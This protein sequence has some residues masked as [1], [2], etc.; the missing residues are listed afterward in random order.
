MHISR[1]PGKRYVPIG[2]AISPQASP[3]CS[4]RNKAI[5]GKVCRCRGCLVA[6]PQ[7]V[8]LKAVTRR[9]SAATIPSRARVCTSLKERRNKPSGRHFHP[10]VEAASSRGPLEN[11]NRHDS[12]AP[13]RA[14]NFKMTA[15]PNG[16]WE[17]SRLDHAA[18]KLNQPA[19]E[20]LTLTDHP[21]RELSANDHRP[22]SSTQHSL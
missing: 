11:S 2:H 4:A 10:P 13:L 6:R 16:P 17:L 14:I 22:D 20:I 7:K 3:P 18:G 9:S 15:L 12:F 21:P 1:V 19:S 5:H 8:N